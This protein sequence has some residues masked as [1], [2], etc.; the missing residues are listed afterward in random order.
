MHSFSTDPVSPCA[1]SVMITYHWAIKAVS[2]SN[3]GLPES[4]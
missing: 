3:L 1:F 4:E 2:L